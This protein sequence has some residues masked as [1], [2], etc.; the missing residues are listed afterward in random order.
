MWQD[1]GL[2]DLW[3]QTKSVGGLRAW[4]IAPFKQKSSSTSLLTVEFS[5]QQCQ[6]GSLTREARNLHSPSYNC[7]Y[8]GMWVQNLASGPIWKGNL[9]HSSALLAPASQGGQF[10]AL[11][12]VEH[13]L[14]LVCPGN[15]IWYHRNLHIQNIAALSRSLVS[16]PAHLRARTAAHQFREL[17][18]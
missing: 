1:I 15:L 3:I 5:I 12:K 2:S 14:Q 16:D 4:F 17:S 9:V 18:A 8:G 6:P 11:A 10:I 13:S 7:D